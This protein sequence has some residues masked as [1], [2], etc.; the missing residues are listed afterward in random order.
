MQL[1]QVGVLQGFLDC[2]ALAG[3]ELKHAL[4]QVYGLG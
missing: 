3:V 4:H 1:S 2:D